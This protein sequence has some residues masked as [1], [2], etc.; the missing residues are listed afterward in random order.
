M[1]NNTIIKEEKYSLT[2]KIIPST[3]SVSRLKTLDKCTEYFRLKYVEKIKVEDIS[4]STFLGNLCHSCLEFYYGANPKIDKIT[5]FELGLRFTLHDKKLVDEENL[6]LVWDKLWSYLVN[7]DL[8]YQKADP[9]YNGPDAI[10]TKAGTVPKNPQMTTQWKDDYQGMGLENSKGVLDL[11]IEAIEGIS[12]ADICAEGYSLMKKYKHPQMALPSGEKIKLKKILYIELPI[13][14][15]NKETGIITNPVKMPDEYGGSSLVY[16]NGYLDLVGADEEGNI[17]II[18]HKTSKNEFTHQDIAHNVQ[19]LSYVWAF[20]NLTG[21]T[22]KYIGIN[23]LRY[24]SCN[25]VEVPPHEALLERLYTLFKNHNLIEHKIF[26][27]RTPEPYSPCLD[28]YGKRCPYLN[29]CWPDV[30]NY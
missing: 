29:M 30:N 18:D 26:N 25:I 21:L 7:L 9:N 3:Y 27:K 11:Y 4:P 19:L 14:V 8:L 16:L 22:V 5:A 2:D 20:E 23:N 17:A 15:I 24:G 6:D 28:S 1:T 10:R 13:S 12:V